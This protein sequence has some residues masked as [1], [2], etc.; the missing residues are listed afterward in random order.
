MDPASEAANVAPPAGGPRPP[1]W[2]RELASVGLVVAVVAT[3]P[4]WLNSVGFV[5]LSDGVIAGI[6]TMLAVGLV[7]VI[8]Y[9]GQIS[10]ASNAFFGMGGYGSA[11]LVSHSILEPW[12]AL[13]ASAVATGL[14]AAVVGVLVFRLRGHLLAVATL[15]VGYVAYLIF[16]TASITGG[17]NGT[18]AGPGLSVAGTRL[19]GD[20]SYYYVAWIGAFV[21]L[22]LSRNLV[23]SRTGRALR[24]VQ[25]S[26]AAAEASGVH[27]VIYKIVAFTVAAMM[28]SLA[29]SI[30]A[31]YVGFVAPS[32]FNILLTV[33]ILVMAV[34][35]GLKSVWGAPFGVLFVL[36]LN[37]ALQ[38]Y[39]PEVVHIQPTYFS[40]I[41]F[42]VALI[43]FLLVLPGGLGD[44]ASRLWQQAANLV[45]AH[46]AGSEPE[47]VARVDS[48]AN[49][50]PVEQAATGGGGE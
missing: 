1:D 50:P 24:A 23:R 40:T 33:E 39:L 32:S 31:D 49:T 2:L 21:C 19:V 37:G 38:T 22:V 3:M 8:G 28:G 35:G 18:D 29:G 36:G 20:R 30:Y 17:A 41:G 48:A 7:L 11:I 6:Y 42:G 43:V 13:V 5:T 10:L 4:T 47:K 15:A 27:P 25:T 45:A 34:V 14:F 16:V 46:T 44:G 9:C 26:E 12:A